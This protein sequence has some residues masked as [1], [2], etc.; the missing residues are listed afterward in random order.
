M[1]YLIVS[2]PFN[3]TPR[4]LGDGPAKTRHFRFGNIVTN[5]TNCAGVREAKVT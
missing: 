4:V 3:S 1:V 2:V 5:D